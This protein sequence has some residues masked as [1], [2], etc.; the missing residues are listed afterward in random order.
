MKYIILVLA[1]VLPYKAHAEVSQ[2]R[3]TYELAMGERVS[4]ALILANV[5][6]CEASVEGRVGMYAVMDVVLNRVAH[7]RFP[8]TIEDVVYQRHQFECIQKGIQYGFEDFGFRDVYL[9]ALYKLDGKAPRITRATH[10]YAPKGMPNGKSPFWAKQQHY[11]GTIGNH[12][13]YL[14]YN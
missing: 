10:Y 11:L 2:E 5:A 7:K 12:K 1:L 8:N 3:L 9:M 14:P 4:N 6:I 13:F